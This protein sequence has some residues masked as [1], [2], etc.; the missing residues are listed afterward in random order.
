MNEEGVLHIKAEATQIKEGIL[1]YGYVKTTGE[2][3]EY[4]NELTQYL[5][6]C[7]YLLN[8]INDTHYN[9]LNYIGREDKEDKEKYYKNFH[10][11]RTRLAPTIAPII[12][13]NID[14]LVKLNNHYAE[15]SDE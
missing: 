9:S 2:S 1:E 11:I 10:N 12:R 6:K 4:I 3:M 5:I 7:E 14:L 15:A 8:C 13:A